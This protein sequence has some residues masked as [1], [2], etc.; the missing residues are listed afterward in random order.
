MIKDFE[1]IKKV[2]HSFFKDLYT[3]PEE[4]PL[5]TNS[6][7][8]DLI[9]HLIH[10]VENRNLTASISLQEIKT[11]LDL[12]DADKAPRPDGFTM[13]FYKAYWSTIKDD[14]LKMVRK[15]QKCNKIDGNTNST[16]LALIPK[17]KGALNFSR[18][19]PISLCNTGYKIITKVIAMRLK[20]NCRP[21]S[22]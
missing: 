15:S 6:Y 11:G 14:L 22:L 2:A 4:I 17:E 10:E 5:D 18:F 16:F 9:P 20:K 1:E 21:S 19:E 12:M 3:A 13:R 7:P 8:L